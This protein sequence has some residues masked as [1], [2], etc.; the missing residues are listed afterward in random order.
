MGLPKTGIG[1]LQIGVGLPK[2]GVKRT[3]T[4]MIL[5]QV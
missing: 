1:L 4:G 2:K 5:K 3:N